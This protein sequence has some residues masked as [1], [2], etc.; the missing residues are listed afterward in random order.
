VTT[1]TP[2]PRP[3][4]AEHALN[5][6]L[7]SAMRSEDPYCQVG[8]TVLSPKGIVLG[9]GYNGTAPG[10]DIDWQ[11]R[12]A[13]RPYVIH[14]E[15]N[16]LRYVTPHTAAGGLLATTH[17][18]CSTCVLQAAA[19]GIAEVVWLYPP[20]WDRYPAELTERIAARLGVRL[21]RIDA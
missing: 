15:Q 21:R 18:P 4:W 16:A 1:T 7:A 20:D 2:P 19:Y 9:V 14:A 17:F 6:A 5:I 8:A 3:T 13:R 10:I 11:D 12:D